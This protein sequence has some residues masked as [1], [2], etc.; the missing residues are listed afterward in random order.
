MTQP[1]KPH[2]LTPEQAAAKRAKLESILKGVQENLAHNLKHGISADG[3]D[4]LVAARK[5]ARRRQKPEDG[6]PRS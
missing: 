5:S 2:D 3:S 1:K 6:D 4:A